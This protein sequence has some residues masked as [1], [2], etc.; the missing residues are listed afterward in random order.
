[1]L[2][3]S[4]TVAYA[5][6]FHVSSKADRRM[7]PS[8]YCNGS[9]KAGNLLEFTLTL[10]QPVE[11]L[12]L[13]GQLQIH[14]VGDDWQALGKDG[15]KVGGIVYFSSPDKIAFTTAQMNLAEKPFELAYSM[16]VLDHYVAGKTV[17][18]KVQTV[19]LAAGKAGETQWTLPALPAGFYY[20]TVAVKLADKAI[21]KERLTFAVDLPHFTHPLTRPA[22]FAAFWK[23]KVDAMRSSP[24]PPS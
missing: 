9:K 3:N 11:A 15:N 4:L 23:T 7:V 24:S 20:L 10:G 14:A 22:D 21:T 16:T 18:S 19:K 17:F 5:T 2:Q 1:M 6:P 13:V 12:S 8:C